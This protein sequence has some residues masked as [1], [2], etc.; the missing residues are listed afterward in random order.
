MSLSKD[1]RINPA[2]AIDFV[3]ELCT[4]IILNI[5]NNAQNPECIWSLVVITSQGE[6]E[7]EEGSWRT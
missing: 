5:S 1:V 4:Y 7:S 3:D 2:F 6:S